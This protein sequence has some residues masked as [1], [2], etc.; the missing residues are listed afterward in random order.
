MC[1]SYS[2][3]KN[4]DMNLTEIKKFIKGKKGLKI[5]LFGG[6]PTVHKDIFKIVQIIKETGNYPFLFTNGIKLANLHFVRKLKR[7][8][9][10]GVDLSFSG[11]NDKIYQ[12]YRKNSLLEN[13]L[14]VIANLQKLNIPTNLECVV[15]RG[16][17]TD[18]MGKIIEFAKECK[19]IN[20][21]VF[22]PYNT[23]GKKGYANNKTMTPGE[24]IQE[25]SE[26]SI[27][28]GDVIGFMKILYIV[29]SILNLKIC[30][31]NRY[32]LLFRT[33]KGLI[34]VSEYIRLEKVEKIVTN[35]LKR[36]NKGKLSII[37]RVISGFMLLSTIKIK[38]LKWM[39]L[40]LVFLLKSLFSNAKIPSYILPI[41]F[42]MNC[43]PYFF[44][45]GIAVNCTMKQY[46]KDYGINN[47]ARMNLE[48][49]KYLDD[50]I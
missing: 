22:R 40:S 14:K 25:I 24:I 16:L 13:K 2:G 9:L 27:S 34:S 37:N 50:Y 18:E 30:P 26:S 31:Y 49:E 12:E 38:S 4:I 6:E 29:S 20:S 28:H 23:L 41:K 17:N 45:Y 36:Y 47:A 11:F 5:S 42:T 48:N 15:M 46:R 3:K 8:G 35:H 7:A 1:S 10:C 39:A 44:D 43:D 19:N 32:Y 21:I 33:K